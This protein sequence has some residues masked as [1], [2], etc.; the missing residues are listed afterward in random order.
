MS[1]KVLCFCSTSNLIQS[2]NSCLKESDTGF[3]F[4]NVE[5]NGQTDFSASIGKVAPHLVIVDFSVGKKTIARI[6]QIISS[7]FVTNRIPLVLAVPDIKV[8]HSDVDLLAG[9]EDY[10]EY[11][12]ES[13]LLP[14]LRLVIERRMRT[15]LLLEKGELF[16]DIALGASKTG[17]S[18][19]VIDSKGVITWANQGFE[20][21]YEC[22][23]EEF[24]EKFG[25]N[26]F[27]P[28]ERG[29]NADVIKSCIESG[30]HEVYESVWFT[31][32]G[33]RKD[34][35]TAITPIYDAEGNFSKIIAIESDITSLKMAQKA[36]DEKHENLLSITEHLEEANRL[37][38]EQRQEIEKQKIS[39]EE[40]KNRTDAL[41]LNILPEVAAHQLKKKGFVRPKK[42]NQV[43]VLFAD[44]VNFSS[45]S[46]SYSSIE[47]FLAV[48]T[49][50]FE[51]Y[52]EI[53]TK[54]FIEKIKTIGDC[55]MCVGGVP[56]TNK[57]HAFDSVL[58]ALEI[59][60]L[61][62]EKAKIDQ[63]QGNPV[64]RARIGIHTGSV[65]A[66]VIGKKKLAYDVWGDTVNVAS[67]MENRGEAGKVNV[68]ESTYLA[69]KDFFKCTYRGKVLAKNIGE[70][71][72]YF[73]ERI[74]PK[75][76]K[77]KEG[78]IPNAAFR[79]EL[80]KY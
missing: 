69:I 22:T 4:Q 44:F 78:N 48:L 36:L 55:Y 66:G 56:Q 19:L 40:E 76:S 23:I 43:S 8:V 53:T 58:A 9:F 33:K 7:S 47:E 46:V 50:Y 17:S 70:I 14:R 24:L 15:N 79:K 72:M 60:K 39:L 71:N 34:I 41:L 73:V 49:Y 63:A 67:R 80:A 42:Y 25:Q 10:I 37:L 30:E 12:N 75:Y 31:K 45:L 29:V 2:I 35:Q 77:D 26:M 64:W 16:N 27:E 32:S 57:S 28:I 52:D 21:L 68:S 13:L 61:V 6:L 18:I 20:Y 74:L 1:Y 54:R 65:M 11:Q 62:E 51:S 5:C 38:D 3:N 59:Q